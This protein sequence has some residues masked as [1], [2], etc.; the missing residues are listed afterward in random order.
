MAQGAWRD[1][2]MPMRRLDDGSQ[3]ATPAG[4][5]LSRMLRDTFRSLIRVPDRGLERSRP[6]RYRLPRRRHEQLRLI[7]WERMSDVRTLAHRRRQRERTARPRTMV[8]L[9]A[10]VSSVV[11]AG[12]LTTGAPSA[13]AENEGS[14]TAWLAAWTWDWV[15]FSEKFA[16]G[17]TWPVVDQVVGTACVEVC[18]GGTAYT[19]DTRYWWKTGWLPGSRLITGASYLNDHVSL[20]S[21]SGTASIRFACGSSDDGRSDRFVFHNLWVHLTV[22]T[23]ANQEWIEMFAGYVCGPGGPYERVM[24]AQHHKIRRDDEGLYHEARFGPW[25]PQEDTATH[26]YVMHRKGDRWRFLFPGRTSN[27]HWSNTAPAGRAMEWGAESSMR[28]GGSLFQ[29][30]VGVD[31]TRHQF[32]E[33]NGYF[34]HSTQGWNAVQE[35]PWGGHVARYVNSQGQSF[36]NG[37]HTCTYDPQCD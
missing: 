10:M 2:W 6:L 4:H 5:I 28:D 12:T 19:G 16:F 13:L 7:D 25:Y 1:S 9:R 22:P 20:S 14:T 15:T 30:H 31:D 17:L 21:T 32:G 35:S 18:S 3:P 24:N 33:G 34:P 8:W 27:F 37:A 29:K 26:R 11:L 23:E 36:D